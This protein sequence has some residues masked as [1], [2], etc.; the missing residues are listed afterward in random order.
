MALSLLALPLYGSAA[1]SLIG[2]GTLFA[3][4]VLLILPFALAQA[5]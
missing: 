3:P 1:L 5:G 2:V 4:N